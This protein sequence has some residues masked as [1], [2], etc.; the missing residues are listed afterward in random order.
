[1]ILERFGR[2]LDNARRYGILSR[3][4]IEL[5]K[6]EKGEPLADGGLLN[7]LAPRRS[8]AASDSGSMLP[9]PGAVPSRTLITT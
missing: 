8:R 4:V 6:G 3:I 5:V 2:L 7:V 9:I 1:M